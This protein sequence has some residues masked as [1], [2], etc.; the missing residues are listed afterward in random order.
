MPEFRRLGVKVFAASSDPEELAFETAEGL[1]V[2][3]ACCVS[4]ED[5]AKMGAFTGQRAT[6][7]YLHATEFVLRPQG[8]VAASMYSTTQLGRMDPREVLRFIEARMDR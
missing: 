8:V 2:P 6:G 5:A 4:A 3:V 7:F 1:D